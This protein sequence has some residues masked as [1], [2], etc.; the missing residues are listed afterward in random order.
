MNN[1]THNNYAIKHT[2]LF[3][4]LGRLYHQGQM[5]YGILKVHF[6][7][8]QK[9]PFIIYEWQILVNFGFFT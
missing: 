2:I 4:I 1:I 5:L 6:C 3:G 9:A 7:T 8:G